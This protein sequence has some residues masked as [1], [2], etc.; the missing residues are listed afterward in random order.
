MEPFCKVC[1]AKHGYPYLM[2][3]G[4]CSHF[5]CKECKF[6]LSSPHIPLPS[7]IEGD[8]E[9][10]QSICR[11]CFESDLRDEYLSL[12]FGDYEDTLDGKPFTPS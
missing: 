1:D 2:Y 7:H 11:P 9:P 4:I 5:I 3:C 6:N 10:V 12:L 8:D